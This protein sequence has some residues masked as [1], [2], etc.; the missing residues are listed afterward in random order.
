MNEEETLWDEVATIKDDPELYRPI[1]DHETITE[2][3]IRPFTYTNY[4]D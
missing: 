4:E 3:R 1:A 2:G